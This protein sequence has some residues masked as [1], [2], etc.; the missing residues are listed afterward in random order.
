MSETRD[1]VS[2]EVVDQLRIQYEQRL[3][4]AIHQKDTARAGTAERQAAGWSPSAP[5]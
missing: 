5:A 1:R 3:Q 4:E 2:T